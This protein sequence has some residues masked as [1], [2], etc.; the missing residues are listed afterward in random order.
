MGFQ[1]VGLKPPGVKG[2]LLGGVPG[3][4]VF[5][6]ALVNWWAPISFRVGLTPGCFGPAGRYYRQNIGGKGALNESKPIYT[7][8]CSKQKG[9]FFKET[10]FNALGVEHTNEF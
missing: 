6:G 1:K 8:F 10:H 7:M 5:G 3:R 9:G 2:K 4:N